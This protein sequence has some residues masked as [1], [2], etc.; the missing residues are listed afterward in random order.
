MTT[1]SLR[2]TARHRTGFALAGGAVML[3]MAGASAP[4]P[5]YPLLQ[6]SLGLAPSIITLVFAVYAVALLVALLTAGSLSDHVG[7][8]PVVSGGLVLLAVS[9]ALLWSADSAAVLLVAR[10][11]QGLASGVLL[12]ALSAMIADLADPGRPSSAAVLNSVTPMAGLASG[13]IVSGLVLEADE[14]HALAVVFG[15]LTLIYAALAVVVWVVPE[16][17]ARER[18]WLRALRPR[19]AVPAPARRLFAMSVPV[20]LA[21][22]ATGGLFLSLG[23]SIVRVVLHVD[24]HALQGLT[25]GVLPAAGA[26]AVLALRNRPSRVT[27]IYGA[28]ALAV[29]T[30]LSIVA[31][32]SGSYTFYLLAVVIAGSGFGPAFMGVVG[33]VIPAVA[34][35]ERAEMFASLYTVSYLAFGIPAVIAGVLT[36]VITLAV[37]ATIYGA[38]VVVL[39]ASAAVFRV[40]AAA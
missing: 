28:V 29:G 21:G 25:I 39:A 5:F 37:M 30:L 14:T 20:I 17:S 24:G 40:R 19:V 10:T 22:W 1:P 7:R 4:S 11:L 36:P 31:L 8:R 15:A 32:A 16:T 38:C 18:G 34:V 3:M 9:V 23:A 33:T 27:T 35:H 12:A 26:I 6:E 2:R 13:A